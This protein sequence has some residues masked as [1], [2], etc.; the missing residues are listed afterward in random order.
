MLMEVHS[1]VQSLNPIYRINK[2]NIMKKQVNFYLKMK[3][4]YINYKDNKIYNLIS[5]NGVKRQQKFN[6]YL[7]NI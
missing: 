4:Y 3:I 2:L 6:F 5:L 1:Y 7:K